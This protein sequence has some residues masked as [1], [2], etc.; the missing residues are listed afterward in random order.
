[1]SSFVYRKP[2]GT[3]RHAVAWL[4]V[5]LYAGGEVEVLPWVENGY[6]LVPAPGS[7]TGTGTGTF[8]LGGTE[9]FSG[10]LTLLNH[11]R[12]VLASGASLTHWY[13]RDNPAVV[14][15]HDTEYLMSTRLVPHYRAHTAVGSPLWAR[16]TQNYQPLTQGNFPTDMGATG[17]HADIGLLPEWDVAY[18]TSGGDKRALTAILVHGAAAGRYGTHYRDETTQRP[19][20]F[21]SYPN[22]VMSESSGVAFIGASSTNTYTPDATGASPPTYDSP[23]HPSMGY[24]AYLVSGWNYFLEETQLL[25]TANF[26]KNTDTQRKYAQGVFESSVG[27]NITR[28]AAWA[29]RTLAQA[30]AI[31]PDGD[32]LRAEFLASLTSNISHYHTRYV[33]QPNNPLG[34]VEPYDHYEP[35]DPWQAAPWMDDFFTGTIGF[36]KDLQLLEGSTAA[37]LDAFVAWKYQSIVGRLGGSGVEQFSYRYAAQYTVPYAK[38][39]SANWDTG[40]GPWYANWGEVARAMNLPTT[41][42]LGEPL[43]SGYP[44]TGTAYWGNLMPAIS[45]AVD[46]GAPGASEG[47]NRITAASNFGVQA[48]DYNDNPV[49]S[50]AP[51]SP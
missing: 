25:A 34:L 39:N 14:F 11:Q 36:V 47:W 3:D 45:Y 18:L 12:A 42:N 32:A 41:G 8:T 43:E 51:R 19:L 27:A 50:V 38:T 24:M 46:H 7:K 17:Y 1:M 26:L 31:T 21:S 33:A 9:R 4:E 48:A 44:E 2:L 5:R 6:L 16:L 28:G 40:T 30:T 29:I 22:L 13:G 23:H 20:K 35:T 10:P 49:W 37:K 15:S